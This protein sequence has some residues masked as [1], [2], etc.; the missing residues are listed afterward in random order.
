LKATF[1]QS[2]KI[3]SFSGRVF[4]ARLD[5]T[6]TDNYFYSYAHRDEDRHKKLEQGQ[7]KVHA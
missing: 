4:H 3:V 6:N 2:I 1:L 7:A 5:V